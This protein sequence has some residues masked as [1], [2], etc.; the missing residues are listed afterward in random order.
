M[1]IQRGPCGEKI[2]SIED[3]PAKQA[4][5]ADGTP[6]KGVT[7][8]WLI[9]GSDGALTFAMRVFQA[10]P[11]SHIPAHKH[12]WEHEIFV[13][14]G[15]MKVRIE[16]NTYEVRERSFIFIPPNTEHEYFIGDE[17]VE[18]LCLIPL[19]PSVGED[20]NPCK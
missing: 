4:T 9:A 1:T 2:G 19:K 5:L 3:V 11:N 7:I 18:F 14:R 13:L 16:R 6:V 17:G 12:P 8:R 15:G 10:E 20:Y